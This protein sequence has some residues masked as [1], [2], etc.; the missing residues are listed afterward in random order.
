MEDKRKYSLRLV[1][2]LQRIKEQKKT[3]NKKK[4]GKEKIS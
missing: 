2:N 3:K 1:I 4:D